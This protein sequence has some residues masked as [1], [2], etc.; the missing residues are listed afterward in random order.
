VVSGAEV[1]A[2]FIAAPSILAPP[3]SNLPK[4]EVFILL[5]LPGERGALQ[6][7]MSCGTSLA[8]LQPTPNL[9]RIL[10][11]TQ[12]PACADLFFPG[13]VSPTG[14]RWAAPR[15]TDHRCPSALDVLLGNH[16]D[17]FTK[18]LSWLLAGPSGKKKM[19]RSPD[20]ARRSGDGR[21]R[22]RQRQYLERACCLIQKHSPVRFGY[23]Q[24][25]FVSWR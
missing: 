15:H 8:R 1:R 20:W 21:R 24:P 3:T 9:P 2:T 25:A 22:W 6:I 19:G 7:P 23:C 11:L 10:K 14:V 16:L 18:L 17:A 13:Q 5:A 4:V 12:A